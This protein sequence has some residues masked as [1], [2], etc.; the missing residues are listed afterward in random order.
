MNRLSELHKIAYNVYG[1]C[2]KNPAIGKEVGVHAL[3]MKTVNDAI[4]QSNAQQRIARRAIVR[5][6]PKP[7]LSGK[8]YRKYPRKQKNRDKNGRIAKTTEI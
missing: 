2:I 7:K 1:F 3:F 5:A 8:I 6:R 4:D